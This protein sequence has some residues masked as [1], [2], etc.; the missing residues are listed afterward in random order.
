MLNCSYPAIPART[1]W[2]YKLRPC[3]CLQPSRVIIN[4]IIFTVKVVT[5]VVTQH[6]V[7]HPM[8][9]RWQLIKINLSLLRY[10]FIYRWKYDT[11]ARMLILRMSSSLLLVFLAQSLV[12]TAQSERKLNV[13][14]SSYLPIFIC[15]SSVLQASPPGEEAE[16][17]QGQESEDGLSVGWL[18]RALLKRTEVLLSLNDYCSS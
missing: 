17:R 12:V 16:A 15:L 11:L 1:L 6:L 9:Q 5:L 3:C 8:L 2:S 13:K 14:L 7:V 10:L 4:D 18:Q